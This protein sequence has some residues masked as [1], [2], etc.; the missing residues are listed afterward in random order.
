MEICADRGAPAF[1]ATA[2]VMFAGP[3]PGVEPETVIQEGRPDTVQ[4]QE[5]E[6][7]MATV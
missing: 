5:A 1:R 3:A 7:W 2:I 6:V 4:E